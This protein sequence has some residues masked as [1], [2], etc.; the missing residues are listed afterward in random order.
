MS[1]SGESE[2]RKC[3][4]T[5]GARKPLTEFRFNGQMSRAGVRY[6]QSQCRE[7]ERDARKDRMRIRKSMGPPPS[8]CE[9]CEEMP[10]TCCDHDHRTG[11]FRGWLCSPCN[12][13]LGMLGDDIPGILRALAYLAVSYTHL[14]L[15]TIYSV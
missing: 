12:R 4:G 14:T 2:M 5:C 15:P 3:R 9:I 7:C 10:A 6:Q 8:F 1:D 11:N 13:A